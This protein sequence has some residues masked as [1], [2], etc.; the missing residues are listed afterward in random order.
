VQTA[1]C[2]VS[3]DIVIY[4]NVVS[5]GT[6]DISVLSEVINENAMFGRAY[7]RLKMG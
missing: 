3:W 5:P 2:V 6:L 4:V 1:S 7:W